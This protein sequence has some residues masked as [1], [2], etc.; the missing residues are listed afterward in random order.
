MTHTDA[1]TKNKKNTEYILCSENNL[2]YKMKKKKTNTK[3]NLFN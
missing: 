1:H 3:Q 2:F